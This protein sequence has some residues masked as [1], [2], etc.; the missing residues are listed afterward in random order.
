MARERLELEVDRLGD[1]HGDLVVLPLP[2]NDV[3]LAHPVRLVRGQE[4]REGHVIAGEGVLG[5]RR[6]RLTRVILRPCGWV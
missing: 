4:L 1:V 3:D 5:A 2:L 6:H